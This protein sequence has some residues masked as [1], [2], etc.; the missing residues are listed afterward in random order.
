M[1]ALCI[2]LHAPGPPRPGVRRSKP[3]SRLK[4]LARRGFRKGFSLF[5]LVGIASLFISSS[6][7]QNYAYKGE[8]FGSAAYGRLVRVEDLPQGDGANLGGGAGLRLASTIGIELEFNRMINLK[9]RPA[10]CPTLECVGSA[11]IGVRSAIIFSA[12][13]L[14]HF[15]VSRVQ[16][17]VVGGIGVLRTERADSL[18]VGSGTRATIS[19]I[20]RRDNGL[21][22]SFGAGLKVFVTHKISLRPEFRLY[23][24]SIRSR[25]NLNLLRASIGF[26]YHW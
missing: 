17:Y 12:N 25:E 4:G 6:W 20:E 11:L 14:Y 21:S 18:S 23:T 19:Q 3:V 26:G 24:S 22:I 13:G 7:A 10:P 2:H 8:V 5:L 15:S 16:P 9:L 1:S